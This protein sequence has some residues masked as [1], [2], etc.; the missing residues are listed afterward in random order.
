MVSYLLLKMLRDM[1]KSAAA[2]GVA[3]LIVA[4]GFAGYSVLSI[5]VDQLEESKKYFFDKT[6]FCDGFAEVRQAPL[7]ASRELEAIEGVSR[8]QG[9]LVKNVRVSG[10]EQDTELK[11]ISFTPDGL[12]QPLLSRGIPPQAGSRQIAVGDGFFKAHRM[13]EGDTLTLTAGGLDTVYTVTGSGLSPENI[14]LVKNIS[15]LLPTPATFDAAFID[16]GEAARLLST[17]GRVNNFVF[18]LEPGVEFAQ[19]EEQIEQTLGQYGVYSVY[20]NK[21]ELSVA[22]LEME[23]EQVGKVTTVI[24]LMF[25]G[26]SAI[27]LYITL[28]RLIEQ[29][30]TQIGTLRAMG[31][32]ARAITLHYTAYGAVVGLVGGLGGG[33]YGSL[34][35]GTMAD[36]Y[37]IFFSLP[38]VSVPISLKYLAVGTV[39][40][41]VFC[42]VVGGLSVRSASTLAPAEALRPAPP[43]AARKFFL[44]RLPG[45]TGMFTVPGVMAIRSIARNPRRSVLS[46]FGIA[47][48]Y[49]LTAT[50]VS[51]NTMFDVFLFDYLEKTQQQDISVSF[52]GPVAAA[53]ALRSV[54]SP[55]IEL[56]EGIVEIPMKLRGESGE[57]DCVAQGI[58]MDSKLCRLY[59][60]D[61]AP[62]FVGPEGVVISVHMAGQLGVGIGDTLE[63]EVSYPREKTSRLTVTGI[64]A[65]YMGTSVYLSTE[66]AGKIS[67][68]RDVF[69]S[70][71]VKA[72][73]DVREELLARL[74]GASMV[75]TVQS[76]QQKIDQYREMMGS[77]GGIMASM[78]AMGVLVGFAIIYTGSLIGFEELKR[79]VSVMRMLG[80]SDRQCL[81]AVTVSQWVLTCGAVVIG[82]PMTLGMSRLISRSMSL[83]L[84]SIPDFVDAP[85]LFLSVGLIAIAV[86]WSNAVIFRKLKKSHL[87]NYCARGNEVEHMKKRYKILFAVLAAVVCGV[88][89]VYFLLRPVSVV[90]EIVTVGP[91]AQQVSEQ[92][93]MIP[94]QQLTISANI[95]GTVENLPFGV[96]QPV[97]A[98]ETLLELDSSQTRKELEDQLAALK[99]QQSAVYSNNY[100][101]LSEIGLRREQ[102]TQ[103]LTSAE[104]EY[105]QRFG[106]DGTADPLLKA[107][108]KN[109]ESAKRAYRDAVTYYDDTTDDDTRYHPGEVEINT[110][111]GQMHAAEEALIIAKNNDAD[112]TE[113]YYRDMIS[114]YETQLEALGKNDA[115]SN[116]SAYASAQQLQLTMNMISEKLAR[117]PL[118]APADAVVW[119][120][121]AEKGD[122]VAENQPVAALYIP[123]EMY[124]RTLV[125]AEDALAIRVGDRAECRLASGKQVS[126][127][128][129]FVSPVAQD[130]VSTIGLT[131]NRCAVELELQNLPDNIGAG[132]RV[133]VTFSINAVSDAISVTAG[134]IVPAGA[135]SAVYVVRGGRAVLTPVEL[136]ARRDGRVEILSG[137]KKDDQIVSDPVDSKVED[138]RAVA[139]VSAA[140]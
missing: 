52:S 33:I 53:D 77:I 115:Y 9:R 93:E 135:G 128:V 82:V 102:L 2:Y 19:V 8:V 83:E 78:A 124:V 76:R 133:D 40:A 55:G 67:E 119:R 111:R 104:Q 56:A 38:D 84:F 118:T 10:M 50:L 79:E 12:N 105:K 43:T 58:S 7:S 106:K 139:S 140:G 69:T 116:N 73:A 46:L 32:P 18:T 17:P 16:Y 71:L 103:Q 81:D 60:E 51:M 15:E 14:Y 63:A 21:D 65:Q 57:L 91:L 39:V 127:R 89:G 130:V 87:S 6:S 86:I 136:G 121:M 36:F 88:G 20:E 70:V 109:Y 113:N 85:S 117:G 132:Y 101:N 22:V 110:L 3:A 37:R 49:M 100:G 62:V 92:G 59:D 90:T 1:K 35:G 74:D 129:R 30:R 4:V 107:A 26:I 112:S 23:L 31:I 11:L 5:A 44:E 114:S 131:E 75:A 27:I 42:A 123:G 108:E 34:A 80:L 122:I 68:Y 61:G 13:T 120:L 29:Q 47:F 126:A 98:G 72:P 99:L 134:S 64:I 48:A 95:T 97:K 28:H 45:F 24:P 94:E 125:L 96:G 137:L 138:G 54:R 25:L 66:Q 41:T